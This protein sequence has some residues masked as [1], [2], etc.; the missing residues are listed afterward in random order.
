M[1][2]IY[3]DL[4]D[5]GRWYYSRHDSEAEA[6]EKALKLNDMYGVRD[7]CVCDMKDAVKLHVQNIQPELTK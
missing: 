1:Y 6:N 3:R 4:L 2:I 7:F 5:E